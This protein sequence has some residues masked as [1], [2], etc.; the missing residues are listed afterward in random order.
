LPKVVFAHPSHT[1]FWLAPGTFTFGSS[2]FGQVIPKNGDTFI[3]APGAIID[4]RHRNLYAFTQHA[5]GVTIE[6][7]TIENFGAAGDNNNEG[8]VNQSSGSGWTIEHNT[9]EHNAGAGV[10][11]GNH[12]VLSYNCLTR[13]GQYGFSAYTPNG[14]R[15]L[16]VTNN[17]ISYNDTYNWEKA[18]PGCGCTG[19][20]KFWQ[21][22]GAVV[23]GNYVHDNLSV[24]L[25]ADTDNV[26][27][28]ITGNYISG[29]Y[30]E[31]LIYEISYNA[32]IADNTFVGNAIHKGPRNPGFPA[33][34][35][36]VSESGSDASIAG[37][38][39]H[40]FDITDNLFQ[41]NW[42]GVILW[43]DANRFCGSPENTSARTC[44]L[45]DPSVVNISSCDQAHLRNSG[46]LS[47]AL[48]F[49][50][51][52]WKTQNVVVS[53]NVFEFDPGA[54]GAA[55]MASHGCGFNGVFSEYGTEPTWSPYQGDVVENAIASHQ[56]DNFRDNVYDGP[57]HFMVHQQGNVVDFATWR[58][59]WSQDPGSTFRVS[60]SAVVTG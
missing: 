5:V 43:E 14:V 57:W 42:S 30:N 58:G 48:Y 22:H 28:A 25:W 49:D 17:E 54:I 36:Y 35:I 26:G 10:M 47:N 2:R 4:G 21:V 56:N 59:E 33:S 12:D 40:S 38:Y 24:G 51:C 8:V 27:F 6:Y 41:N 18:D 20:G 9:I 31:G 1:V 29:N 52:R 13:N 60:A 44:T 50:L 34:A 23:S 53:G 3:G 32:L 15:S 45:N 11:L 7:L 46:P 55:C 16:T 37:P 39:G 19:G